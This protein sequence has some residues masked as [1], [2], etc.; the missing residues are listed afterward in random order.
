MQGEVQF[1]LPTKEKDKSAVAIHKEGDIVGH[2]P[3]S[4]IISLLLSNFLK[5]ECNKGFVE[6]TCPEL[7]MAWRF[8]VFIDSISY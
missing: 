6:V 8:H 4:N 1:L 3:F 7:D 2:V 5:R